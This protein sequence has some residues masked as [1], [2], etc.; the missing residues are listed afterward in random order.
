VEAIEQII[1]DGV[2]DIPK[3]ALMRFKEIGNNISVSME[4]VVPP[5]RMD[6]GKGHDIFEAEAT[7]VRNIIAGVIADIH[8]R[9]GHSTQTFEDIYD[10]YGTDRSVISMLACVLILLVNRQ[11][12]NWILSIYI[13]LYNLFGPS[14]FLCT[15]CRSDIWLFP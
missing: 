1:K 12:L 10:K 7:G 11:A 5:L 2:T 3:K 8:S 4:T 14:D 15:R 9:T 13:Y 6:I